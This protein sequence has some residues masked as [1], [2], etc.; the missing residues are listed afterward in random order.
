MSEHAQHVPTFIVRWTDS[1]GKARMQRGLTTWEA[2]F[3][4]YAVQ[5]SNG[6]RR[7]DITDDDG[8]KR[9]TH[10]IHMGEP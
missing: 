6:A 7:A 3:A 4:A 9:A 8:I 10:I 5:I 2:A 1:K